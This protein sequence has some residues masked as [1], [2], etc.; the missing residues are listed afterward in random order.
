MSFSMLKVQCIHG[1]NHLTK[2][3]NLIVVFHVLKLSGD[4]YIIFIMILSSIFSLK[5]WLDGTRL[6]KL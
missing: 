1:S 3:F 5:K 4:C 6:R 2:K